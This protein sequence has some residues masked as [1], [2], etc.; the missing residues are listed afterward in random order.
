MKKAWYWMLLAGVI[1][2]GIAIYSSTGKTGELKRLL[3]KRPKRKYTNAKLPTKPSLVDYV[4]LYH[5][6]INAVD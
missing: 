3:K 4:A 5:K 2:L 6:K 1:I